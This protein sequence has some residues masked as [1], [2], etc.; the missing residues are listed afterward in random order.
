[1]IEKSLARWADNILVHVLCMGTLGALGARRKT[2]SSPEMG[3]KLVTE[4][5][6]RANARAAPRKQPTTFPEENI[7][8]WNLNTERLGTWGGEMGGGVLMVHQTL[9]LAF[10]W[11]IILVPCNP[12]DNTM[13]E[14]MQPMSSMAPDPGS[15]VAVCS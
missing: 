5:Q 8:W 14:F 6:V 10:A 2:L 15:W 7:L 13:N 4:M 12:H 11:L 1:M 3:E 9:P